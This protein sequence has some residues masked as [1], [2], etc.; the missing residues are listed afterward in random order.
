LYDLG[1]HLIDQALCLFGIPKEIF[2]EMSIQRNGA[3]ATDHFELLLFYENLKVTLKA[4]MLV[5]EQGSDIKV[6]GDRGS[7][8]KT[9]SDVQEEALKA[10]SS[11]ATSPDWGIEPN[12]IWGAINTEYNGLHIIGTI[13]SEKGDYQ[14]FYENVRDAILEKKEILVKPELARTT[15]RIIELAMKSN[16]ERHTVPFIH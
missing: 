10:G 13:E 3:K 14:G 16:A 5:R 15:I 2:A 8:V 11:P 6:Y 1:A 4:G 7:F 9:K 12:A